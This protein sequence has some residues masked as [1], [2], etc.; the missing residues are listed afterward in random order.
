MAVRRP[1]AAGG[2]NPRPCGR[3]AANADRPLACP[4]CSEPGNARCGNTRMQACKARQATGR[5]LARTCVTL[6]L[7]GEPDL[8]PQCRPVVA[9]EARECSGDRFSIVAADTLERIDVPGAAHDLPLDLV[10]RAPRRVVCVRGRA[11]GGRQVLAHGC[12]PPECLLSSGMILEGRGRRA[13][14]RTDN[15][16]RTQVGGLLVDAIR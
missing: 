16:P 3:V 11:T 7:V 9:I 14:P 13:K 5:A 1:R 15:E 6:R 12:A 10:E 8:A 4:A 2:N